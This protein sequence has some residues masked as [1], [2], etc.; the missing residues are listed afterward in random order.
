MGYLRILVFALSSE[1][2]NT[3]WIHSAGLSFLQETLFFSSVKLHLRIAGPLSPEALMAGLD[4]P[5]P[6]RLT[7]RIQPIETVFIA[8][9][10]F[11]DAHE[12]ARL[13]AELPSAR[14][15]VCVR[16][17]WEAP[18]AEDGLPSFTLPFRFQSSPPH[19][20]QYVAKDCT[21]NAAAISLQSLL[22]RTKAR[23]LRETDVTVLSRIPIFHVKVS[24]TLMNVSLSPRNVEL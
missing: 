18:P 21:H 6:R 1:N 13:I 24:V 15:L 7:S 20:L 4:S 3:P 5:L 16:V 17:T 10:C 23:R 19:T 14:E 2:C 9:V 12:F 8:D 11:K 22:P